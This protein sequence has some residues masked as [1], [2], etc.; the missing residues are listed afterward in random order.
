MIYEKRIDKVVAPH[1]HKTNGFV[2]R[3]K[4]AKHT[5]TWKFLNTREKLGITQLTIYRLSPFQICLPVAA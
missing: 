2:D 4:R 1:S 5:M 3:E